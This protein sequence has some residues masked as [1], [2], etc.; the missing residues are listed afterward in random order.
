MGPSIDTIQNELANTVFRDSESPKKASGRALGTFVEIVTYYLIRTWGYSNSISIEPKLPE[1]GKSEITHN[2]EFSLNPILRSYDV[3]ISPGTGSISSSMI[4]KEL[5]KNY[6]ISINKK[7]RKNK[8]M[9][10]KTKTIT[11]A[12]KLAEYDSVKWVANMND[13]ANRIK[14]V[15]QNEK[16]YMIFECKRVG[17]EEGN[18]KGPQTIEKAK[19]GAYVA[20]SVSSLQKIRSNSGE[21]MGIVHKANGKYEIKPFSDMLV[22][23]IDSN[24]KC[25]LS[26][27]VVT[28]GVIS[29]H[30]N[31]FTSENQNKEMKVLTQAYDWVLFLTD[32]G[33]H[34]FVD[35]LILSPK[36]RYHSIKN[37]FYSS[38]GPRK[39]K[40]QFTKSQMHLESHLALSEYFENNLDIIE[41]WFNVIS[42]HKFTIKNLKDQIAKLS[43][44]NWEKILS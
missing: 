2:V 1:Y 25:L 44:K 4:L 8:D 42:P 41:K 34:R 13:Q 7:D 9:L 10:S 39:V 38:Y 31:W 6:R 37:A 17:V 14:V 26:H 36:P 30:G 5:E 20:K 35:D 16:P 29:N 23:I 27:F 15:M 32:Q 12:C 21:L 19:Q 24:D 22:E 43:S 11:N 40:N 33:L 18:K 28:V 3:N